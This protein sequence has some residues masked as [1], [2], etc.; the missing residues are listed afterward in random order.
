MEQSYYKGVL[1]NRD[2]L[3]KILPAKK[4]EE[5]MKIAHGDH[6]A[7]WY[8]IGRQDC[9]DALL[10]AEVGVVPSEDEL[11]NKLKSLLL[12]AKP[13]D[14]KPTI[15]EL[16]KILN[17]EEGQSIA[18]LPNGEIAVMNPKITIRE[19]ATALRALMLSGV[20]K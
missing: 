18:M 10:K 16:E 1:M 8:N 12:T 7:Y 19:L 13:M 9:I 6:R 2:D 3:E 4:N 11:I 5:K 14:R 15:A 17:S 20:E